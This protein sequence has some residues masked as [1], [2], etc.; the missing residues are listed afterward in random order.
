MFAH[1]LKLG[2]FKLMHTGSDCIRMFVVINAQPRTRLNEKKKKKKQLNS[3]L[4]IAVRLPAVFSRAISM[5][6]DV[7]NPHELRGSIGEPID[8][9]HH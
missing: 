3:S 2:L 9:H 7:Q 4:H 8:E 5:S 1:S 6:S